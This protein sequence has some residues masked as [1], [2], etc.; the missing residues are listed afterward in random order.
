VNRDD[1]AKQVTAAEPTL[2]HISKS[3]LKKDCDCADAVQEAIVTAYGKLRSLRDDRY[4]KTWLCRIL[5]HECYRIYRENRRV[6]SLEEAPRTELSLEQSRDP[7]LFTA[8]MTLREELRL[9]IVLHYVEGFQV[10]EIAE[11]LRIP[12]GTVKSRLSHARAE[13]KLAL[14]EKEVLVHE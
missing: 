2:Y 7:E 6:V 10:A 1:F 9:V 13:L 5:I 11:M 4:F 12:E 14:K 8:I 3:I